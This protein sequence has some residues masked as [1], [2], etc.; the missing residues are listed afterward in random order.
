MLPARARV[1]LV[2]LQV[3]VTY[4]VLLLFFRRP[5]GAQIVRV[6]VRSAPF[7]SD[8]GARRKGACL[9]HAARFRHVYELAGNLTTMK[10]RR[11]GRRGEVS[12]YILRRRNR[13]AEASSL[14]PKPKNSKCR[15]T[16]FRAKGNRL[17]L[18]RASKSVQ[19][20]QP[21]TKR[22]DVSPQTLI[23]A[24]RGIGRHFPR[25][26]QQTFLNDA[27]RRGGRGEEEVFSA[28][29]SSKL[30]KKTA[31][32]PS[33]A[34]THAIRNGGADFQLLLRFFPLFPRVNFSPASRR[35]TF[36]PFVR[37]KSAAGEATAC[38]LAR[39][40]GKSISL[41]TP[42]DFVVLILFLLGPHVVIMR[43]LFGRAD[44]RQAHQN[45]DDAREGRKAFLRRSSAA[46][47]EIARQFVFAVG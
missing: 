36:C 20:S 18:T 30:A 32:R 29:F 21:P 44:F 5:N 46:L 26:I 23:V 1:I 8:D 6:R 45:A 40:R 34:R 7:K 38:M 35:C 9:R 22:C 10:S 19:P 33:N 13:E 31:F 47:L 43:R 14:R 37:A 4:Y 24:R 2:C 28:T 25:Q 16:V 42:S 41:A 39:L 15:I 27:K 17:T 11:G 3:L 12:C